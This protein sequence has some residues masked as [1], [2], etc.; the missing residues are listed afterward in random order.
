MADDRLCRVCCGESSEEEPLFYPCKCSGTIKYVHDNCLIKWLQHSRRKDC[1]LCRTPFRFTKCKCLGESK[2]RGVDRNAVYDPNMPKSM[3]AVLFMVRLLR[4]LRRLTLR[5]LRMALAL[6]LWLG[7]LPWVTQCAWKFSLKLGDSLV[8]KPLQNDPLQDSQM[9]WLQ[10]I[11]KSDDISFKNLFKYKTLNKI[12]IDVLE[13]QLITGIIVIV[14][15]IILLCREWVLAISLNNDHHFESSNFESTN[16][17][18][19]SFNEPL[20]EQRMT[21]QESLHEVSSEH[22]EGGVNIYDSEDEQEKKDCANTTHSQIPIRVSRSVDVPFDSDEKWEIDGDMLSEESNENKLLD[23]EDIIYQSKLQSHDSEMFCSETILHDEIVETEQSGSRYNDDKNAISSESQSVSSN[24]GS[25]NASADDIHI[26]CRNTN[27]IGV[28]EPSSQNNQSYVASQ[29]SSQQNN[30][31]SFVHVLSTRVRSFW[32]FSEENTESREQISNGTGQE[33]STNAYRMNTNAVHVNTAQE[34]EDVPEELGEIDGIIELSGIRG[35]I[36]SLFQ[37][38]LVTSVLIS[39]FLGLLVLIPYVLGKSVILVTVRIPHY[40][41]QFPESTIQKVFLSIIDTVIFSTFQV[42]NSFMVDSF[43]GVFRSHSIV[44]SVANNALARIMQRISSIYLSSSSSNLEKEVIFYVYGIKVAIPPRIITLGTKNTV[45]DRVV[46]IIIGYSILMSIG[47][48]Y[49]KKHSNI[50]RNSRQGMI[51]RVINDTLQQAS[52]IIKF[53]VVVGIEVIIFPIYCGI[54]IDLSLL[55][56]FENASINTRIVF[57]NLNPFTS[58]FLHWFIGTAYMFQFALF[59]KM[60]RD[61]VRPGV[62][63]FIHD[64]N[65]AQFHPIKEILERPIKLQLRKIFTSGIIY[66]F[67]ICSCFLS[68]VYF[69][70]YF[71]PG[72]FPLRLS[73]NAFLLGVPFDILILHILIPLTLKLIKPSVI[74]KTLWLWWLRTISSKLRL[75]SFMFNGRYPQ[76]EGTY[77]RKTLVAK[78]LVK[79]ADIHNNSEEAL[80][81]LDVVFVRDGSFLRVPFKDNIPLHR[82]SIFIPVTED[83]VRLDKKPDNETKNNS[84]FTVVYVPPSFI[85]RIIVFLFLVWIFAFVIGVTLTIPPLV[86]GRQIFSFLF[87]GYKCHDFYTY[88]F[89]CYFLGILIVLS[90]FLYTNKALPKR[91]IR[92]V[93]KMELLKTVVSYLSVYF[94][95]FL[96]VGYMIFAFNVF[97]PI[98]FGLAMDYYIIIP[99]NTYFFSEKNLVIHVFHDWALGVLYTLIIGH[100]I[101][102]NTE[103]SLARSMRQIVR[104]GY[105]DPD[106]LLSTKMFIIP[107]GSIMILALLA[108]LG[109][110]YLISIPLCRTACHDTIPYIYR[111]SYPLTLLG[112]LTVLILKGFCILLTKCKQ[113]IRDEVYLIGEQLHNYSQH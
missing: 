24:I 96:K 89:G 5:W 56:L 64:P 82:E 73:I 17:D 40:L 92:N 4:R 31:N 52:L 75:T 102:L 80:K 37:N 18:L 113:S 77:V 95:K 93:K 112:I 106:I 38:C 22:V 16:F 41:I 62:L 26:N 55:D 13:G 8:A 57:S 71:F 70:K 43:V 105:M 66:S 49:L 35:P 78:L 67:L 42:I 110:G 9:T 99:F 19:N 97:L 25:I 86:V 53:I 98:L 20:R 39:V 81:D 32:G 87:S 36:S 10:Y 76:E 28:N 48:L 23:S 68:V 51:Q 14:F 109:L 46:S 7:W 104:N 79:K 61:I 6:F 27:T 34:N 58:Y 103:S 108:P 50:K 65:D 85:K 72:L 100:L 12:M 101:M 2:G 30:D 88:I 91:N 11:L 111:Y 47:A 84:N 1:E 33:V 60:C 83:N 44:K 45:F 90:T 15:I 74:I 94:L 59:V 69:A 63:F 21:E 107:F 54:L 3:P 29:H